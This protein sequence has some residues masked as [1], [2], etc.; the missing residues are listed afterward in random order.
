MIKKSSSK[1]I[2][3]SFREASYN[4]PGPT[5]VVHA[6]G[7]SVLKKVGQPSGKL[8]EKCWHSLKGG[9]FLIKCS[10]V[11]GLTVTSFAGQIMS[12]LP[13]GWQS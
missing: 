5:S 7:A 3:A 10:L 12:T 6:R 11:C 13:R 9:G 4:K 8:V 1:E 2:W